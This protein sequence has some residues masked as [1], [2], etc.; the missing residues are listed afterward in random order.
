MSGSKGSSCFFKHVVLGIS[1][2]ILTVRC[3][4]GQSITIQSETNRQNRI[5][6]IIQVRLTTND[7][8]LKTLNAEID[9]LRV[10]SPVAW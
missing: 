5:D 7:P 3:V 8:L 6:A 4:L 2:A 1:W 10:G 9:R